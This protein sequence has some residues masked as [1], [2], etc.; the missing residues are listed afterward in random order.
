MKYAFT[1]NSIDLGIDD[2]EEVYSIGFYE[3][4]PDGGPAINYLL[5]QRSVEGLESDDEDALV[6]PY[7]EFNDPG[8]GRFAG[9]Y[10]SMQLAS[11]CLTLRLNPGAGVVTHPGIE[12]AGSEIDELTVRFQADPQ[13]LHKLKPALAL[14]IADGIGFT[15]D[16]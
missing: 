3:N 11:D 8:N 9:A 5:M 12:P 2:T 14:V 6:E 15:S 16:I 7:I 13:L 1:A 10:R 4:S